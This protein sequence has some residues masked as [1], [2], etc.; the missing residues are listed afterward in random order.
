MNADPRRRRRLMGFLA[1]SGALG[2]AGVSGWIS[3]AL[4]KGDVGATQGIHRLEGTVSVGGKPAR[5]GTPVPLGERVT[6]GPDSLAV[7][8]VGEDAF[9]L[10]ANTVIEAR[11]SRGV[12]SDLL[13]S[14]GRVLTVF[15]KKPVE[16][17][18]SYAT[19]GIRG[20]GAYFEIDPGSV[21]FCLCYGEALVQGAGMDAK[22]VKT[23]HHEQPL[24]LRE[25]GGA[26]RAEPGPFRNHT[27]DELIMLEALVGRVPPF[28]K[29]G[30]YPANKY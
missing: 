14:T 16:I 12:L 1:A 6:T 7:V 25:D 22:V 2:A 17:K 13:I 5:V 24:L 23:T 19:I 20:T 15:S 29:G 10:R 9:L 3:R 26:M 18:A 30:M 11:G 27:D 4:A 28:T 8:V 21:Y